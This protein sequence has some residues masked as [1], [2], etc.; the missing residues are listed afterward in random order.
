M[1]SNIVG[2]QTQSVGRDEYNM[3]APTFTSTTGAV[4]QLKDISLE[5]GNSTKL[6]GG[7]N[8]IYLFGNAGDPLLIEDDGVLEEFCPA[9]YAEFG[10]S[11]DGYG[12]EFTYVESSGHW[13]LTVDDEFKYPMDNYP[14]SEG[15]GV[16]LNAARTLSRGLTMTSAGAVNGED[17]EVEADRD[18]YVMTGNASPSDLTLSDF[19]IASGNSTKLGGGNNVIYL[20]GNAGDPLLIEEDETLETLYPDAYAE[21]GSSADGYGT[22]FTFVESS[23]HWYLT[24]DDSYKYPMD[25][26]PIAA[27]QGFYV[28]AARTLAK[29]LVFTIPAA[30][31]AD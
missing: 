24:V 7:N 20:F 9:A 27:G 1:H 4:M 12:T 15:I 17:I 16:Y 3:V 26:Y 13:Y 31:T 14:L 19:T 11:A 10:D 23:G 18:E 8:V 2:Y 22:E 28:N 6:S 25:N 30:V 29:G 21:F 5:S